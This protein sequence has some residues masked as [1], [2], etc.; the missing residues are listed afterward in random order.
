MSRVQHSC[1]FFL[2]WLD[3]FFFKFDLKTT[4]YSVICS[5]GKKSSLW[6]VLTSWHSHTKL[7]P[8]W[9]QLQKNR[10]RPR[11]DFGPSSGRKSTIFL[12]KIFVEYMMNHAVSWAS[13]IMTW[14]LF[15]KE[16]AHLD[17][18]L[19]FFPKV[20]QSRWGKST[21]YFSCHMIRILQFLQFYLC[22]HYNNKTSCLEHC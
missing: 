5:R 13:I 9:M 2:F 11:S 7:L 18:I 1:P 15:I 20:K 10:P 6:K 14:R 21:F 22:S 4:H 19:V 8:S 12:L 17:L 16:S 3:F